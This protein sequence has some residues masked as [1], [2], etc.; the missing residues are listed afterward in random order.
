M[1]VRNF[2]S[3][4]KSPLSSQEHFFLKE[5]IDGV[6]FVFPG[7]GSQYLNMGRDLYEQEPVFRQAFDECAEFL[8]PI[9]NEDIREIIFPA[10]I[11]SVAEQ[12]IHNT[13]Y[14]QPA[15]FTIEYAIAKLWMS[16]GI[17]PAALVGHSIG[18]FVAAHLA[19]V[20][21]L[22]AA[23]KLIFSRGRLMSALPLGSMLTVRC[24]EGK[25]KSLLPEDLSIAAIN[26][27]D[28]TVISGPE[29]SIMDFSAA[30]TAMGIANKLLQT[31]HAFHSAMMDPILK[32]FEELA[33]SIIMQ[34]PRIPI[35]S[36]LTG[37]WIGKM[38]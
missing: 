29:I 9:M 28:L 33:A 4:L 1:T 7:Q 11:D 38:K 31:S 2:F 10:Q 12:K 27:P 15:L 16:W 26:G 35:I 18:E 20:F 8:K 36:T 25:I 30:L 3:K 23:L 13:Y 24:G 32:D 21:S 5:N 14:T 17:R 22:E 19:G 37:N 6:V 34:E